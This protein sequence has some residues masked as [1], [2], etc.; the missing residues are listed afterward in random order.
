[1]MMF[2]CILKSDTK[3]GMYASVILLWRI[4]NGASPFTNGV[5]QKV[6]ES[7]YERT[8]NFIYYIEEQETLAKIGLGMSDDS[9][10]F[11]FLAIPYSYTISA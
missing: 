9:C 1:M 6:Q 8:E 7:G 5:A 10:E 3:I 11:S 2:V 4:L